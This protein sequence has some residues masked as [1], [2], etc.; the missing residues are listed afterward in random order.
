MNSK[1]Q[2]IWDFLKEKNQLKENLLLRYEFTNED[3]QN[4]TRDYMIEKVGDDI[5]IVKSISVND[6]LIQE[7]EQL[8]TNW[9]INSV[10]NSSFLIQKI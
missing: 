4:E 3:R 10:I 2:V 8:I 5:I 1:K 9:Q 7:E 6:V